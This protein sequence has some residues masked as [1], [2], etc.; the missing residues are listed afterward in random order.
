MPNVCGGGDGGACVPKTCTQLNNASGTVGDGCGVN[1]LDCGSCAGPTRPAPAG[2]CVTVCTPKTCAQI[3]ATCGAQSDGCGGIVMCGTCGGNQTCNNN[4]CGTSATCTGLCLQQSTCPGTA[5]TSVSGTV[6]APNGADPLPNTLVYVPNCAV[7]AFTPGVSCGSCGSDVSGCPLVSAVTDYAGHFTITNMPVGTNIPLVI[8]NGRWRR[9]FVIPSVAAC[10]NTALPTT[11]SQQLRMPRTHLEGDIPLMAF[12]T[13]SVD[14]LECVLRKIGIAD[15]EFTDPSGTGRV[16]MYQGDGS[17]GAVYS[18]NT[19]LEDSLWSSQATINQYDMVYFACQGD[20]YDQT[21]AAQNVV[22]NYANAGGRV[23]ATHYSYVWLFDDAWSTT[24]N[25]KVDQTPNFATDPETGFIVTTFPQG[26]MLAQWLKV[27][28]PTSTQGQIP[29]QTL[30]HDF[31]SVI[32][33]SQLWIYLNDPNYAAPVPMHY[34]FNTPVTAQPANQCGR[35][36]YDDFHVEDASTIGVTKV[37]NYTFPTEC[38]VTGMSPQEK[39]LEFMIFDLGSCVTP[40][41]CAPKTCAQ[42]GA[43]CGEVGDGCSNTPLMC[44]TCP[45]GQSCVGGVCQGTGCIP[46]TCSDQNFMCGMQGDGCGNPINCGT[47]P[48]GQTCGAG[49]KPGVCGSGSCN[50]TSCTAAGVM[51]GDIGDGC[52]NLLNCGVCP[53]GEICGGGV[54]PKPG[55]CGKSNCV[56]KTCTQLGFNC[57]AASDGCGNII[58]CGTCSGTQTCGGSGSPNICGGGA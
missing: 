36:L 49:G 16:R 56:P 18:F 29:I 30:R 42:Q 52:G 23:F 3:G 13:G 21:T 55:V 37:T 14:A 57:G 47:C 17:P 27:L 53:A 7:Q 43:M 51:C 28:Y 15:S 34:T 44:G 33:P 10:V 46:K 45:S 54:N 48:S 31:D 32:A 39:M 24:A 2:S 25:W 12:V 1:L 58:Q 4:V 41:V 19:P 35:V 8:Q 50:P 38:T 26:M 11:G 5:T 22:I 6:Y 9:Q 20:E 40:P